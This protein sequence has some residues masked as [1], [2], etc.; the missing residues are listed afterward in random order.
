[1]RSISLSFLIQGTHLRFIYI[2][3]KAKP[4]SLPISMF[5]LRRFIGE[6]ILVHSCLDVLNK[7][8]CPDIWS[9]ISSTAP[10][11]CILAQVNNYCR[12]P[13]TQN[14]TAWI[15]QSLGA[16]CIFLDKGPFTPS[17]GVNAATTLR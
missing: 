2:R 13:V 14:N 15:F 5:V 17:V 4:I 11:L 3:V 12:Y 8:F 7:D 16:C 6:V 10:S 1:M 9:D